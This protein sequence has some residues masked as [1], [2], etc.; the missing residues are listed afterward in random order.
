MKKINSILVM[1]TISMGLM[2]CSSEEIFTPEEST[3]KLLENYTVKRNADGSYYVDYNLADNAVASLSTEKKSNSK[4]FYLYSSDNQSKKKFSE[5]L[6]LDDNSLKV[7]F[8]DTENGRKTSITVL[9]KDIRF[10]RDDES[11]FLN[12]YSITSN[13]NGDYD[14][15]F[16]VKNN[17]TVQFVYND[18]D[19]VYEIHLEEG[20]NTQRDYFRT[21]VKEEGVDLKIDFLNHIT[22]ETN[23]DETTSI[24]EKPKIIVGEGNDNLAS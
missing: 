18:Q 1:L 6:N 23:R 4:D 16:K 17:V 11:D 20:T 12:N 3:N 13:E 14:L 5:G 10:N 15:D 8:T 24:V 22:S 19:Q 9:D 21:F 7:G 2:S